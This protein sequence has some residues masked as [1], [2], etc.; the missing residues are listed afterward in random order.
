[1]LDERV[2]RIEHLDFKEEEKILRMWDNNLHP[3]GSL[4]RLEELSSR[5]LACEGFITADKNRRALL[6]FA[7]DHGIIHSKVSSGYPMLTS[8]LFRAVS[9]HKTGVCALAKDSNVEIFLVD[10]GIREKTNYENVIYHRLGNETNN[11]LEKPAML[12]REVVDAINFGIKIVDDLKEKNYSIIHTGELGIANTCS[13]SAIMSMVLDL[14]AEITTGLGA[15]ID[16]ETLKNKKNTVD[17]A[18][19]KYGITDDAIYALSCVGGYEIAALTGAFLGAAIHKTPI[20]IDGFIT[21]IASYLAYMINNNSKDYFIA[22]HSSCER[23]MDIILKELNLDAYY[24]FNMRLGEGSGAVLFQKIIDASIYAFYNM[25]KY[26]EFSVPD[27][28]VYDIR[29]K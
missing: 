18:K 8:T 29:S 2:K 14:P 11:F 6:I 26:D 16:E 3:K 15:G 24:N 19:S 7:G 23:Q 20:V 17:L 27:D 21:A 12:R 25:G 13:S 5:I 4:G 10:M 9:E 22:S 1:M 28:A